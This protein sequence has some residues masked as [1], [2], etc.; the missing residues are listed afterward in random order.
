MLRGHIKRGIWQMEREIYEHAG[1]DQVLAAG[2]NRHAS[3]ADDPYALN[4]GEVLAPPTRLRDRFRHL[5]PGLIVTGSVIGS[6]ELVLTTSLGAAAGWS[7]LWWMILS[8][9]CKSLTQAELARYTIATGDTYMRAMNRIPGK[10]GPVSWPLWLGFLAYLPGTMGLGGILGGA[11]ESL[12]FLLSLFDVDLAATL[13]AGL[14][15]V[16]AAALL[17]SGSY[18][19]LEVAMLPLII[20]FTL[21]TLICAIAMQTTEYAI[22]LDEV[23]VGLTPDLSAFVLLSALALSAYGYTGSGSGDISAYTYWCI[24]KGYPAYLGRD[25]NDPAWAERAKGWIKVVQTD[26]LVAVCVISC[27]TL[28]FYMLGAGVLN[29]MGLRPEGSNATISALSNIFTETL[30]HWA[31]W[32]FSFGAFFILFSTVLSGMGA[33]GRSFPDYFVELGLISRGNLKLR[34][35]IIRGYLLVLPLLAFLIYLFVPNFVLL[36]MIGGLTSAL[37]LPLQTGATLWLQSRFMDARVQPSKL[38]RTL[39]WLL[40]VF[41]LGVAVCVIKIVIF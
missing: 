39:L 23:A 12:T 13:A 16:V 11:G 3:L 1:S 36:I 14:I 5:G 17:S 27:A 32:L 40:F 38:M 34:L 37:F 22:G 28:P 2:K 29:E 7:L 8:C 9:W 18:R 35:N 10:I 19:W 31:V 15:A 41:E 4:F 20:G 30:G 33:G 21:A 25:R 24:E 6:G 26:V